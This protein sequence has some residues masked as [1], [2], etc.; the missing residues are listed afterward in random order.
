MSPTYPPAGDRCGPGGYY[1]YQPPPQS[2]Y[3]DYSP[4]PPPSGV[5]MSPGYR[6]TGSGG[7]Q[8]YGRGEFL[9]P[10]RPAGVQYSMCDS[11]RRPQ[12]PPS[13]CHRLPNPGVS[14]YVD[15]TGCD[16]R[17]NQGAYYPQNQGFCPGAVSMSPGSVSS[18]PGHYGQQFS[19]T[20]P[21][22]QQQ[23]HGGYNYA[24]SGS[25][26]SPDP[27]PDLSPTPCSV[28]SSLTP[29]STV[30]VSSRSQYHCNISQYS[31]L[32]QSASYQGNGQSAYSS[33]DCET[34][35]SNDYH[36]NNNTT[37]N[38]AAG[39][40]DT[41][42]ANTDNIDTSTADSDEECLNPLMS[43]Q[44]L[45]M[46]PDSQVVDP[47]TVLSEAALSGGYNPDNTAVG[48]GYDDPTPG[49]DWGDDG[50]AVSTYSEGSNRMSGYGVQSQ[51][52]Q[53]GGMLLLTG[54]GEY[55]SCQ[56][57]PDPDPEQP[58]SAKRA[59]VSRRGAKKAAASVGDSLPMSGTKV[60][61]SRKATGST[62]S[63]GGSVGV[64]VSPGR[65]RKS[66]PSLALT[67]G[68]DGKGKQLHRGQLSA[69]TQCPGEGVPHTETVSPHAPVRKRGRPARS[70]A[71]SPQPADKQK[72]CRRKRQNSAKSDSALLGDQDEGDSEVSPTKDLPVMDRHRKR[73]RSHSQNLPNGE[74]PPRYSDRV[75][76][77]HESLTSLQ[78]SNTVKGIGDSNFSP[79]LQCQKN[80][81]T[82]NLVVSLEK[83]RTKGKL[84]YSA[85]DTSDSSGSSE[86]STAC[87]PPAP[88][89]PPSPANLPDS[90]PTSPPPTITS[91]PDPTSPPTN[92]SQ[93]DL[94]TSS[95]S[96]A[97]IDPLSPPANQSDLPNQPDPTLPPTPASQP[98]P[99]GCVD[100]LHCGE[101]DQE[102]D[103]RSELS[104][105]APDVATD[106]QQ[107]EYRTDCADSGHC[108]VDTSNQIKPQ[109]GTRV[110]GHPGENSVR[111]TC[112]A[113]DEPGRSQPGT[114]P[115]ASRSKEAASVRTKDALSGI[116][117]RSSRKSCEKT[118]SRTSARKA[119]QS[120][121]ANSTCKNSDTQ[122]G[123][124]QRSQQAVVTR[125][126]GRRSAGTSGGRSAPVTSSEM[127]GSGGVSE[128][129]VG[130][131]GLRRRVAAI[132][133][134]F[135][136]YSSSDRDQSDESDT[137]GKPAK[138][139][140][141]LDIGKEQQSNN[142]RISRKAGKASN[143]GDKKADVSSKS[144]PVKN[145]PLSKPQAAK[146]PKQSASAVLNHRK[147]R[148]TVRSSRKR[149]RGVSDS[150]ENVEDGQSQSVTV[151]ADC[152]GDNVTNPA[153]PHIQLHTEPS[154]SPQ[155]LPDPKPDNVHSPPSVSPQKER[156][157]GIATTE[158]AS[159]VRGK[160]S[161]VT[162][163]SS[164][165][166]S[167]NLTCDITGEADPSTDLNQ[168]QAK[169]QPRTD[170][171]V[172]LVDKPAQLEVKQEQLET[173]PVQLE[174]KPVKIEGS[175]V[176]V[177]PKK[178][179]GRPLGSKTKNR[180]VD[181]TL[182]KGR[183][184]KKRLKRH[185]D[186]FDY[187]AEENELI[188]SN[189]YLKS[190]KKRRSQ[191]S[192]RGAGSS[193]QSAGNQKPGPYLQISPGVESC[194]VV[195]VQDSGLANTDDGRKKKKPGRKCPEV[196][197]SSFVF[198]PSVPW[199]CAFCGHTPNYD[200][201]GDLFGPYYP[202]G[203]PPHSTDTA[204]AAA[205]TVPESD[206]TLPSSSKKSHRA[207]ATASESLRS[208]AGKSKR[209]SSRPSQGSDP[210]PSTQEVWLH[211]SCAV[212]TSG[213]H[214]VGR[215]VQGLE[216]AIAIS[217]Q[218]VRN[219]VNAAW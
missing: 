196:T 211:E 219:R 4:R 120:T 114:E 113:D 83:V 60:S 140:N 82:K 67:P 204:E 89:T 160:S 171:A 105:P 1:D 44:K 110:K 59:K 147:V 79:Q 2:T 69:P 180:K 22:P 159:P 131:R 153:Q 192:S 7:Y 98:D 181:K 99:G 94:A 95:T 45:V 33:M 38:T 28:Y 152:R 31:S 148:K 23:Q 29:V 112:Q 58:L 10:Q 96:T 137:G 51:A 62:S 49:P 161:P 93:L 55:S 129:A 97:Q 164:A 85:A 212:W 106:S 68:M 183:G 194:Q 75:N 142:T 30:A 64:T 184:K 162:G 53:D 124:S 132:P 206:K 73:L 13:Q 103:S 215:K 216:E 70:L 182:V 138:Q 119:G 34:P 146:G 72:P 139:S 84:C 19:Y 173:E 32:P 154:G 167:V 145:T 91:Q 218:T 17:S 43:L 77:F 174:V 170:D 128:E 201:L 56:D 116:S 39:I 92:V 163:K 175:D 46:L 15:S 115:D 101:S 158:E 66:D 199:L 208:P 191:L 104:S 74:C 65:G 172:Q 21:G 80:C 20:S 3:M 42:H 200:C 151:T 186:V 123:S 144:A 40:T 24:S 36:H 102:A 61:P 14:G 27:S 52:E 155:A 11:G 165:V 57:Y 107:L 71:T 108:K 111:A 203:A 157:G 109:R 87:S 130:G 8:Q 41:N 88:A 126:G 26:R 133:V 54:R 127:T 213:L 81:I 76:G 12:P 25:G 205:N 118:P 185:Y 86:G 188:E 189:H 18:S 125:L 63:V 179:L 190:V 202:E 217:Q 50:C 90:V 78:L 209:R 141:A 48:G 214:F 134:R 169:S 210:S 37:C 135:L 100:G 121:Q 6:Q 122:K 5:C 16:R 117:P 143:S 168:H 197:P 9:P 47:K 195:N 156:D 198:L 178:R 176:P 187:E 207:R 35:T 193:S 166:G 136:D 177:K 149:Q 150:V